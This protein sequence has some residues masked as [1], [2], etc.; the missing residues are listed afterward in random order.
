[1][2]EKPE[3]A[4]K[5]VLPNFTKMGLKAWCC[6]CFY[7]GHLVCFKTWLVRPVA[8]VDVFRQIL[9]SE[10]FWLIFIID[11]THKLLIDAYQIYIELRRCSI[12][13]LWLTCILSDKA[14]V[15]LYN[16]KSGHHSPTGY[17]IIIDV[18]AT[19]TIFLMTS[20][21]SL[22]RCDKVLNAILSL[23]VDCFH[24]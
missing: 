4:C 1:M 15:V 24:P 9:V 12:R 7:C 22:C 3:Q 2:G 8:S 14:I 20:K 17:L 5:N 13:S 6:R 10:V 16:K 11:Y 23:G 18:W 21:Y 19:C